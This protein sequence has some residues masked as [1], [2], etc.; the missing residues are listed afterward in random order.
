MKRTVLANVLFVT[1]DDLVRASR[2]GVIRVNGRRERMGFM[3]RHDRET[4]QAA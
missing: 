1:I 4:K 2:E 3:F